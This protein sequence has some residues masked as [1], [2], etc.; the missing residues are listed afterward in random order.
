MGG[1]R[2]LLTN[3]PV[4]LNA[5]SILE[6]RRSHNMDLWKGKVAIVTGSSSGIGA[7]IC[8]DLCDQGVIVVGLARRL[9]RLN[10]LK[11]EI[12]TAK[13]GAQFHPAKCDLTKEEE[14]RIVFDYVNLQFGGVDI[15]VNNAGVARNGGVFETDQMDDINTVIATNLTSV[16]SCTKNAFK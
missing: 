4:K 5:Q 3:C 11:V 2:L 12:E 15:L 8:K 16:V 9:D 10:Q 13:E 6:R 7:A 1:Q 14:I